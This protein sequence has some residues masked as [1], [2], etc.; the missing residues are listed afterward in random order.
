MILYRYLNFLLNFFLLPSLLMA[1]ASEVRVEV[2]NADLKVGQP[3]EIKVVVRGSEGRSEVVFPILGGL[4]KGSTTRLRSSTL[5][6]ERNVPQEVVAQQ[7]FTKQSYLEV[8]P[9]EVVVDGKTYV[10]P[11]FTLRQEVGEADTLLAQADPGLTELEAPL[12]NDLEREDVFLTFRLSKPKV[13]LREGFGLYL[14]LFVAKDVRLSMEFYDLNRQLSEIAKQIKPDGCWEENTWIDEIVPR[15]VTVSGRD[16]TEYRIY[17]SVFFPFI[18]K[19]VRIPAVGLKMNIGD[20]GENLKT[21]FSRPVSIEVI[22]LPP[23]PRRDAVAV[24]SYQLVEEVSVSQTAVGQPFGYRFGVSGEGNIA[25]IGAPT[26]IPVQT[27]EF[28]PPEVRQTLKLDAKAV[29]GLKTFDYTLVAKQKGLFPLKGYFQWVFFDP[30]REVY[31]TLRS[32]RTIEVTGKSGQ[33]SESVILIGENRLYAN[34]EQ[35]DSQKTHR[36]YT[37]IFRIVMNVVVFL[38]LLLML[39]VFRK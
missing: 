12:R 27:F 14:S 31:D 17:Q 22:D 25:A 1:Q 23:H 33:V 36:N 34:L 3:F 16:Y 32:Q 20:S 37:G 8:P 28:Y 15:A 9:S 2:E 7:Y 4:E 11:G 38:M 30:I 5:L 10:V 24:G 19:N 29:T 35:L 13:Y 21:F 6:G 39:W 18:L 26:T